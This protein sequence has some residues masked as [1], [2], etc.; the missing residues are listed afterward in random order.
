[1]AETVSAVKSV[2]NNE[3]ASTL[4]TPYSN[5]NSSR[6]DHDVRQVKR[7]D[8]AHDEQRKSSRETVERTVMALEDFIESSKRSLKIQVYEKTGDIM[9]KVISAK[10]GKVIREIPSKEM[11]DLAAKMENLAGTFFNENV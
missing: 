7:M 9:V 6:L 5:N 3:S 8:E 2:S 11:L 10:D 1:M 4:A